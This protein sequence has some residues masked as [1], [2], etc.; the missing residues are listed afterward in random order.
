MTSIITSTQEEIAAM[1]IGGKI[2]A[3]VLAHLA[4]MVAPGVD[5]ASLNTE[6]EALIA[7]RGATPLFLG[8]RPDG[9]S[10]P[11]PAT[12]CVSINDEVV[13][14]IPYKGKIIM[15]GDIVS[16]DLGVRYNGM[17]VDSALTVTAGVVPAR[18]QKLI[19]VTKKALYEGIAVVRAGAR[20]GDIGHAVQSC[21]EREGFSVV[22]ELA[23][24]GVGHHAHE[25]PMI[26]NFGKK[27][28]GELLIAGMTIA[29]E[30]MVTSGDWRIKTD[31]DG[32]GIRTMDG[33][34]AAHFEHTVLVTKD[35]YEIL[36]EA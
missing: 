28:T 13:H 30:P 12:V 1:R 27:A 34:L 18:T 14:A 32:W 19:A 2:L 9:A 20:I 24:H 3:D 33:S 6:A 23:G 4:M 26:L 15:D 5:A 10:S 16:L 35:G 25:E 11:Y 29:I 36:T 21:V 7:A 8:Y 17:C 22:R 31:E